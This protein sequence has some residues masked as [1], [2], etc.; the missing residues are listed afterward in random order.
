MKIPKRV[1]IHVHMD[2]SI[3]PIV[4]AIL[5]HIFTLYWS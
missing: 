4:F 5:I 3:N 2:V 1:I